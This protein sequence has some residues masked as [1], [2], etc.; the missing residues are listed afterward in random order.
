MGISKETQERVLSFPNKL[1]YRRNFLARGLRIVHTRIL[2]LV[3]DS[4]IIPI[5]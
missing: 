2:G 4:R 1:N 3:F 5:R